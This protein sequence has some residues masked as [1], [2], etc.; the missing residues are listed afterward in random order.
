MNFTHKL[1]YWRFFLFISLIVAAPLSKYPSIA[2]PLFNFPSFRIGLY[3][4]LAVLFVISC[5]KPLYTAG[6]SFFARQHRYAFIAL[7]MLAILSLASIAWSLYPARSALLGFSVALLVALVLSAWWYVAT[8]LTAAR[9]QI[10]LQSML[11]A[12]IFFGVVS[13]FQLAIFSLT[14]QTLGVLCPG[15]SADIFGFPR[16]NGLAAEPLFF[17]NAM[18]P[19]VF[20]AVYAVISQPSKLAWSAVVLSIVAIGLTFSRGAYLAVATALLV[21]FVT[22]YTKRYVSTKITLRIFGVIIISGIASLGL[23]VAAATIRYNTTTNIT[24][25]TIDSIAEHLTNGVIDLPETAKTAEQ[26][27]NSQNTSTQEQFESPGLI[28]ASSQERLSAANLAINAW[29]YNPFT[30][31]FGVGVG[32]LG[33]FVVQNIES[34]APDNLTVYI[35][36]I[37]LLSELGIIGFVTFVIAFV[38]AIWR[39][40]QRASVIS[41]IIAGGLFAFLIQFMFFGSYINVM[42]I[43]LWLGVSLGFTSVIKKPKH[44]TNKV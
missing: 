24:Y 12:A 5:L 4:I 38:G 1:P 37:L 18:I 34:T 25:E 32:N 43:W 19:Y 42:Y 14:D 36:Y 28:E 10:V 33:P 15:C 9:W 22:M 20:A 26:T 17:A 39:L 3:Q 44:R 8:E 31:I 13:L 29:Q 2:V 35:Y 27:S 21:T 11:Y 23:L 7:V 41:L 30:V 40:V 16:V 6:V